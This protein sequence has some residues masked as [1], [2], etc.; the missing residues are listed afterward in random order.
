MNL[1]RVTITRFVIATDEQTAQSLAIANNNPR[2]VENIERAETLADIPLSWRDCDPYGGAP[3][4]NVEQALIRQIAAN[5]EYTEF[6]VQSF[7]LDKG[8]VVLTSALDPL[9]EFGVYARYGN[10]MAVHLADF[11]FQMQADLF[12]RRIERAREMSQNAQPVFR[13]AEDAHLEMQYED[14]VSG[15]F[16]E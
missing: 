7:K 14:Q 8:Q 11:P 16:M 12:K 2:D 10:G 4:L 15:L 1:Y 3:G 13:Q 6:C 5:P 9:A